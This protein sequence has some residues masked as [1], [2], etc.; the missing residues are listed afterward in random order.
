MLKTQRWKPDTHPDTEFEV[1]WDTADPDAPHVVVSARVNGVPQADPQG[2][3]DAVMAQNKRKNEAI[4]AAAQAAPAG[5]VEDVLDELGKPTGEKQFK[6][7]HHPEWAIDRNSG[8]VRLSIK[9]S[10]K[11]QLNAARAAL[12]ARF[13]GDVEL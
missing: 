5:L 4:H 12:M 8:K 1:Q 11:G 9:G 2:L 13:G 7:A 10:S 6:A 3:Y